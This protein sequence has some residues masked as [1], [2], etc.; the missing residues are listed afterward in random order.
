MSLA[1]SLTIGIPAFF[2]ALAPSTGSYS[3]KGFLR[4]LARFAMPAG[5]ATGLGVLSSYLFALNVLDLGLVE[6]PAVAVTVVIVV[7]PYL[8]LLALEVAGRVRGAA[9]STLCLV[10]LAAYVLVLLAPFARDFFVLAAPTPAIVLS[11][12]A[13][14]AG[15]IAG[16]AALDDRF[17]PGRSASA[18]TGDGRG[19]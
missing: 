16:L 6:A 3:S 8:I 11:A 12:L 7:G 5:T 15:A 13:G 17:I 4:E 18:P 14:A 1:A 9:V 10:L 19:R 2:L